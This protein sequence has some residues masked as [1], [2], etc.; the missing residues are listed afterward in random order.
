MDAYQQFLQEPFSP[1]PFFTPN[2]S[3]LPEGYNLGHALQ[4]LERVRAFLIEQERVQLQMMTQHAQT[5]EEYETRLAGQKDSS[6]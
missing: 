4:E 2:P 6:Q 5:V 3:I 1:D